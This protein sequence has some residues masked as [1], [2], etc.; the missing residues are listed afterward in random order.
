MGSEI[1]D[2][3][4]GIRVWD[5]GSRIRDMGSGIGDPG[6][7]IHLGSGT[8]DLVSATFEPPYGRA[9]KSRAGRWDAGCG[10]ECG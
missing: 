5:L 2:R 10:E 4:S 9:H 7:G 1:G 8:W 3:E 6:S